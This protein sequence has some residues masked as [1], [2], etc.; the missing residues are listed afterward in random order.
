[1]ENIRF[2]I[3]ELYEDICVEEEKTTPDENTRVWTK[4]NTLKAATPDGVFIVPEGVTKIENGAF[5]V[6]KYEAP[7]NKDDPRTK[8]GV[9]VEKIVLPNSLLAIGEDA[10]RLCDTLRE[11]NI[12][13]NVKRIERGAFCWCHNLEKVQLPSGLR[14]ISES[15][16]HS[17]YSLKEINLPESLE[18]IGAWAFDSCRS[19]QKVIIPGGVKFV[20]GCSFQHCYGLK[21]AVFEGSMKTIKSGTFNDCSKLERIGFPNEMRVI[22]SFAFEGCV[23]LKEITI[24]NTVQGIDYAAF[25]RC[26]SLETVY[27]PDS[28]VILSKYA[29]NDCPEIKEISMSE[30]TIVT[31]DT[32]VSVIK[33]SCDLNIGRTTNLVRRSTP[34]Q[35]S[36]KDLFSA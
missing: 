35:V 9:Y 29:F 7:I 10:F 24:P 4:E 22:E 16:F 28:V 32:H 27:L 8:N 23:S 12:P 3:E 25:A 2:D 13:E 14:K 26:K 21:E 1:M 11:I 34:K 18:E 20:G 31:Y 33:Q 17:C 6:R 15:M 19:L 36:F 5:Y 30:D